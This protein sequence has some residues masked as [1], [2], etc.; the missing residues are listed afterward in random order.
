MGEKMKHCQIDCLKV[1]PSGYTY[2]VFEISDLHL[3]LLF[4]T[5]FR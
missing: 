1:R 3:I 2:M 5:K 4:L